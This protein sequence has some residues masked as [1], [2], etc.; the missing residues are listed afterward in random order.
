[1]L[2]Q[3]LGLGAAAFGLPPVLAPRFFGRLAGMDP[4][5]NPVLAVAYRSVGIRDVAIGLGLWSAAAH[6]G[7]YAPWL[8]ARLLADAGDTAATALAIAAGVRDTRFYG[9]TALAAGASLAG[10]CLW[11]Q[12]RASRSP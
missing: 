6:G 4:G 8:L 1:M 10:A 9:L 12:A 3:A 5:D 2:A 7:N 11:Q